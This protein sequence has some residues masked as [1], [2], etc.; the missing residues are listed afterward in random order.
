MAIF[1]HFQDT[2]IYYQKSPYFAIL[3]T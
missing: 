3:P 2:T 1:Y